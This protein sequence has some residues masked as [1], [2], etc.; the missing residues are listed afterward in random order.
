MRPDDVDLANLDNFLDG[1][2]PWRMFDVLRAEAPIHWQD[3]GEHGSGFWSLTRHEDIVRADRDAET[4]T[5]TKFVNLEEV[6]DRQADIRRSILETDGPR[7]LSLRRLLQRDFTP[8]AVAGYEVFLRGLTA[9]TLDAAL[10]KGTFDFVK[11]VS[12][13]FPIN[14]LARMLDVPEGDTQQLIDWGNRIIGN[15][16]PDY[17]DVLLHSEESEKYR[18]LPF[19]SPASLEV[20]EYGRELA[21]QRRGGD[22]TDLVSRLVNQTPSDGEPLTARDFDNYFLLLVVAGNETTRHAITHTMKA[23]I[24]NPAQLAK[25]RDNPGLMPAAVEE[26]LRWASPV[27][28][29]RRTATKDVEIH[30]QKIAA[31]DKVVMW[32]ASGNR[33]ERVFADPYA[34][35]VT[36]ENN[37][38]ITFGKG[39]PHF[40][41]GNSLAR[42]EIRIMFEELLPRLADIR[43]AG[44]VR[45]V[46]SN[47][48]NGIK[49]LPVTVTLA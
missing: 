3:E 29:F 27:Y 11:E 44:D 45:R 9:K 39:S 1:E 34:F 8:R 5:S 36:R 46:R 49:E 40:C 35:D 32:F 25:L 24:E 28:H 2:T 37:D 10:A 14:V 12:A 16:D 21:R 31:G 48:V 4:F 30:G 47:F 38:H 23:L 22:G 17:A 19:R 41:L 42:L 13:D 7:H 33:D 43:L 18:D 20:F 15:T 6:D 26:F